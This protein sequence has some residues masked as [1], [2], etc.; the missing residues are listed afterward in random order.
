M[1][2]VALF[3]FCRTTATYW[4]CIARLLLW[5][6]VW[7][8]G[9]HVRVL[10]QNGKRYGH[11]CCGI[12]IGNHTRA[13]KWY[14]FSDLHWPLS[15][16]SRFHWHMQSCSL[17]V[18]AELLVVIGWK[19]RPPK[20]LW[21]YCLTTSKIKPHLGLSSLH[22]IQEIIPVFLTGLLFSLSQF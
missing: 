12:L 3:N 18:T 13:F 15:Y 5:Y 21:I 7:L 9:C 2:F 22:H 16:I 8:G 1:C 20:L 17:C 6:G 14:I 10:C 4:G 19:D 11:S